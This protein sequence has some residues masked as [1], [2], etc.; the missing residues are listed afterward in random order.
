M[1][2]LAF[3]GWLLGQYLDRRWGTSPWLSLVGSLLGVAAGLFEVI[4]IARRAERQGPGDPK[5]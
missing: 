1:G 2:V 5:A 3:L 4:T